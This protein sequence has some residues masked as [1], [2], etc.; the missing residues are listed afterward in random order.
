MTVTGLNKK[1]NGR[2]TFL[3]LYPVMKIIL[4]TQISKWHF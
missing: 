4:C 2:H 3:C 1:G